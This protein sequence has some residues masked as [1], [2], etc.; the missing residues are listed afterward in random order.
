[1]IFLF[2][3]FACPGVERLERLEE[4]LAELGARDLE[5]MAGREGLDSR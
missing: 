3:D 2:H 5:D 4:R 1:M